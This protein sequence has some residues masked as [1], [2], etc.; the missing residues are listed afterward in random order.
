MVVSGIWGILG[1]RIVL[2]A[3][4]QTGGVTATP[5]DKKIDVSWDKAS[6]ATGYHVETKDATSGISWMIASVLPHSNV[7]SW[8]IELSPLLNLSGKILY[9]V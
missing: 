6:G 1:P 5:G 8:L 4:G 9:H 7:S 3:P 2:A